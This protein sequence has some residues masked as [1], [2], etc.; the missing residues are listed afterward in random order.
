MVQ[1]LA[2]SI[3]V[4]TVGYYLYTFSANAGTLDTGGPSGIG[5]FAQGNVGS[6]SALV[7][8]ETAVAYIPVV[9]NVMLA[10]GVASRLSRWLAEDQSLLTAY[11]SAEAQISAALSVSSDASALQKELAAGFSSAAKAPVEL[12]G[13]ADVLAHRVF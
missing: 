12:A 1:W 7:A 6:N 5:A 9:G 4:G 2:I 3:L 11:E 13:L 10:G 8:T